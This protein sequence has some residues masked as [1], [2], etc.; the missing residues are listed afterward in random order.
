MRDLSTFPVSLKYGATTKPYSRANPH[1]GLD[2][3]APLGTP[4]RVN[5]VVI[6][7]V[8]STGFSTGN[9]THVQKVSKN[10]VVNPGSVSDVVNL[11]TPCHVIE[12]NT[13]PTNRN[14]MFVRIK[15][16]KGNV[17]T[18]MHLSK[19]SVAE[20]RLYKDDMYKNKNSEQWYKEANAWHAKYEKLNEG[21]IAKDKG[22]EQ[23]IAELTTTIKNMQVQIDELKRLAPTPLPVAQNIDP[24]PKAGFWQALAK[25]F[26]KK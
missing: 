4:I 15:D 1:R 3:A 23:K 26:G 17:F 8:G 6:G 2:I 13:N 16:G 25:L 7:L 11:P 5:G 12:I 14:G 19:I 20:G 18:Y 10:Y 21:A 24:Q 22:Q 9:H